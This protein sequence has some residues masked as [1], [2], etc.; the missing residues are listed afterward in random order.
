MKPRREVGDYLRDILSAAEEAQRFLAGMEFEEFEQDRRT[1][2]ATVRLLET[3]GEA[4]KR[5]PVG[6]RAHHPEVPWEDMAGMRDKLAHEYFGVDLDGGLGDGSEGTAI[7]AG[8]RLAH[9]RRTASV[10]RPCGQG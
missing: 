7:V 10:K 4:V 9:A 8:R 2:L 5:L 6:L 3:I 1:M